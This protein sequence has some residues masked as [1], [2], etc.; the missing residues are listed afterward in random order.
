M[1]HHDDDRREGGLVPDE[2]EL[3]AYYDGELPDDRAREVERWLETAEGAFCESDPGSDSYG[4]LA[5][6]LDVI[7]RLVREDG[8]RVASAAPSLADAI[9]ARVALEA[10]RKPSI[11]APAIALAPSK[12]ASKIVRVDADVPTLHQLSAAQP[13]STRRVVR[14]LVAAMGV[15]AAAAACLIVV[16]AGQPDAPIGEEPPVPTM[17]VATAPVLLAPDPEAAGVA[18]DTVDFGAKVGTI[19]LQRG[20]AASATTVVWI[21]DDE[22]RP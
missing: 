11:D 3:M 17:L 1:T 22:A 15:L 7:G 21:K 19:F 6:G 4:R 20:D 5:D 10:P 8:A 13:R 9:M 18:V 2:L 14:Q 12:A 16:L